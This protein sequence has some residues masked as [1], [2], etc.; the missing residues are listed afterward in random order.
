VLKLY[1]LIYFG[2][3]ACFRQCSTLQNSASSATN[4]A[5]SRLPGFNLTPTMS[6][7]NVPIVA[8]GPIDTLTDSGDEKAPRGSGLNKSDKQKDW[9]ELHVEITSAQ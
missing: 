5:S 6:T 3:V 8:P 1:W 9:L 7:V 4:I 2:N